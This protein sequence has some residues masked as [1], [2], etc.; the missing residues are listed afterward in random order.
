MIVA[1]MVC[2]D[3]YAA[4]NGALTGV[5][6]IT[7]GCATFQPWASALGGVVGGLAVLPSSLFVSHVLKIDDPVDAVTVR[8]GCWRVPRCMPCPR[9]RAPCSVYGACLG[10]FRMAPENTMI[11]ARG[12]AA[13]LAP[14]PCK[15]GFAG[16]GA[17]QHQHLCCR[18][19]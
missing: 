2:Q 16:Q 18:C 13:Q 6:V 1:T 10:E 15:R 11:L 3:L 4:G 17:E 19:T 5:V 7:S 9:E 12:A 8:S 14:E